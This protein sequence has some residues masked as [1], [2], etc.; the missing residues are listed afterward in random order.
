MKNSIKLSDTVAPGSLSLVQ[1]IIVH[2]CTE[3]YTDTRS[4]ISAILSSWGS[5][6]LLLLDFSAV[7]SSL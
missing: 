7:Q 4:G 6:S 5:A 3:P 2:V 1:F